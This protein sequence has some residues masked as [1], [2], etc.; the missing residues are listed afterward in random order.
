MEQSKK[1]KIASRQYKIVDLFRRMAN[2]ISIN[3][4][5]AEVES[6]KEIE[7][8]SKKVN[9]RDIEDELPDGVSVLF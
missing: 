9:I 8:E 5:K 4:R 6:T 3:G 7:T 2:K 1:E